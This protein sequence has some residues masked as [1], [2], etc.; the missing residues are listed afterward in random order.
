MADKP[1]VINLPPMPLPEHFRFT[2]KYGEATTNWYAY[3]DAL[4]AWQDAAVAIGERTGG[5]S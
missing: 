5:G 1:I 4:K 2:D 3:R